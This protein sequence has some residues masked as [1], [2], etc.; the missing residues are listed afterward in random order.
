MGVETINLLA[1]ATATGVGQGK[2]L[3]AEKT[4][5]AFVAGTGAVSATV[6][7]EVSNNGT[8]WITLATI[9]LSGTTRAFDGFASSAPWLLT[10]AKVTAIAG[11]GA[12]VTVAAG[13]K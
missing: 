7:I 11:A 3:S 9:T 12:A 2:P 13:S 6:V 5:Q 10:R 8:D 4:V 1:A